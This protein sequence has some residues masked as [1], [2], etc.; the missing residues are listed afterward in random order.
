VAQPALGCGPRAE[1]RLG[2]RA[3]IYGR[4]RI[5]EKILPRACGPCAATRS[6]TNAQKLKYPSKPLTRNFNLANA[7][8]VLNSGASFLR[9]FG[10]PQ[11]TRRN[12]MPLTYLDQNALLALGRKARKS[13]YRS[14]LDS[15]LQSAGLRPV[16]SSWHLIET[17]HTKSID[18]AVE[19]ADFIDSLNPGWLFERR[20]IQNLDVEDDFCVFLGLPAPNK[21]RITA[22]S[23]VHAALN[24]QRDSP[25]FDIPSRNFVRQW[26]EHPKQVEELERTYQKNAESL[27]RLR[28]LVRDGKVTEEIRRRVD[29]IMVEASLPTTT[30][31][32]LYV[33][34]ELRTEYVKSVDVKRIP[35]L[36]IE[37]AISEHE[38]FAQG[39]ADRNTLID[40][41]HLISALPYADEI[42]SDDKFFA[43]IYPKAQKTGHVKAK[44][45]RNEELLARL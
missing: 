19:L 24:R 45:L 10:D 2:G 23:A 18:N 9:H 39:G 43:A 14:K 42:V 8:A 40:K 5:N 11:L 30:P 35:S 3:A 12:Q 28:E 20:D 22:R 1:A 13:E 26:I 25:R 33:G 38:W 4:E 16:V 27:L 21:P 6:T 44:L 7:F 31:A 37:T 29:K 15:I 17:A 34:Q 36:A 32:G 41:F